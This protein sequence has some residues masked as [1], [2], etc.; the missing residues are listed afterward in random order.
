MTLLLPSNRVKDSFND[1]VIDSVASV[2]TKVR[3]IL[4]KCCN[5]LVSLSYCDATLVV[6]F[7][8]VIKVFF[9]LISATATDCCQ[10]G[11]KILR[12]ARGCAL[13]TRVAKQCLCKTH[14]TVCK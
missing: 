6:M 2:P 14:E 3:N 5:V 4:L 8:Q 12:D 10:I 11:R 1:D 9:L 7:L 13:T